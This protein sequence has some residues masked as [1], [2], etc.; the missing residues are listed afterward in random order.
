MRALF[1]I[2]AALALGATMQSASATVFIQDAFDAGTPN[3]LNWPGDSAF[4][5]IPQPG[6][7][8]GKPSVD[9]VGALN[10]FGITTF[11]GNS[12]DL[13]GSTGTGFSPSGELQST[14]SLALGNYFVSFEISANQ[15]SAP[16]Q[17]VTVNIGNSAASEVTFTP[18]TNGYDLMTLVFH[19]VSGQLSF[20][21]DGPSTQMGPMLDNVLVTGVPEPTTWAMIILG[22]FG[23]GFMAYRRKND[24]T[25]RVA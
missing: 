10:N 17:G 20:T 21:A 2:V 13:D 7:V 24:P 19:N 3:T 18:S 6:N 11:S 16:L 15:R 8:N 1:P 25:F 9:L 23:V 4:L 22:F 12:V 14:T 5:S